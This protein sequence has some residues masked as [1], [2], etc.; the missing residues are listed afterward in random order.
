MAEL[1]RAVATDPDR[2]D[3]WVELWLEHDGQVEIWGDLAYDRAVGR[4]RLR[5]SPRISG[6]DWN[7]DLSEVQD[8]LARAHRR[9]LELA[10]LEAGEMVSVS[11]DAQ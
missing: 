8:L 9:A 3:P 4:V 6:D 1:K 10:G 11:S 7:F 2:D 5:I